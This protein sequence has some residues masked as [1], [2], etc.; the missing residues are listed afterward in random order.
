M[1]RRKVDRL[2]TGLL[3]IEQYTAQLREEASVLGILLQHHTIHLKSSRHSHHLQ[4]PSLQT[5]VTSPLPHLTTHTPSQAGVAIGLG[6]MAFIMF[7][8]ICWWFPRAWSKGNAKQ[9]REWDVRLAATR[10]AEEAAAGR[11]TVIEGLDGK[12][13]D[14]KNVRVGVQKPGLTYV[15]PVAGY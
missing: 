2:K 3:V 10:D 5:Y 13:T 9:N 8:F 12:N 1:R 14:M 11:D 15:P 7:V 4:W 6:L